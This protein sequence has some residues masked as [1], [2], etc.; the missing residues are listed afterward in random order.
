MVLKN[1]ISIKK[2]LSLFGA[3]NKKRVT[4]KNLIYKN[5]LPFFAGREY[6]MGLDRLPPCPHLEE[7][8]VY[9]DNKPKS[10]QVVLSIASQ[11]IYNLKCNAI[12]FLTVKFF[13]LLDIF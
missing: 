1:L 4:L 10:A 12:K 8:V 9:Q 7:E 5:H 6:S 13:Q 2:S 11:V 3:E